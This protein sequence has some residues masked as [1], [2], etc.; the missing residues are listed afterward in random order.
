[1]LQNLKNI[2]QIMFTC[3]FSTKS[4]LKLHYIQ[5]CQVFIQPER[6]LPLTINM[7][8]K[9]VWIV[10]TSCGNFSIATAPKSEATLCLAQA[11]CRHTRV[12]VVVT[13]VSG[14][15]LDQTAPAIRVL[16]TLN[17]V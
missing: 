16:K 1:M 2:P 15:K 17:I 4:R 7:F 9:H 8:L 12:L 3:S 11:D 10:Q 6:C 5:L 13:L 14:P